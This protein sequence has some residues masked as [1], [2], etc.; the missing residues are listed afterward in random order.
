MRTPVKERQFVNQL[1]HRFP[2]RPPVLIGIGDDGAVIS[3]EGQPR[4]VVVTD[5]LLDGVHFDLS[6]H[7]IHLCGRKAVAVNLS[8][9]AAMGCRP[10]AAFVSIA[11][12]RSLGARADDFLDQI[13]TGIE[14]LAMEFEFTVAG[15]DTNVWDGPFAINVCCTGVPFGDRIFL[16]S[17]AQPGD[18]IC[19]TGP[20]GGSYESNRHLT[21]KPRLKE[22]EWL[23]RHEG[24][25]AVMDISDGLLIDLQ[26]LCEASGVS[27]ALQASSIP[28]HTSLSTADDQHNG[29]KQ[30][31]ADGEDFELL[32]TV[33]GSGL[34]A[35]QSA[36]ENQ[37]QPD[38]PFSC[39]PIGQIKPSDAGDDSLVVVD[40]S[41]I[42]F[43]GWEHSVG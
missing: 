9:L 18:I 32:F 35:L 31:V 1:K 40:D 21:F 10:T 11:I 28:L 19:V 29:W 13:Y 6:V 5:M 17:N 15:G 26:R 25:H 12:P 22:A 43:S 20:L 41:K 30:A 38:F 14:Q 37:M 42:D 16:R 24:V 2:P 8:D 34:A 27:A 33:S 7:P 3:S 4:Q 23:S 36:A 39:V